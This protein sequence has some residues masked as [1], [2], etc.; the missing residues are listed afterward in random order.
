MIDMSDDG[1]VSDVVVGRGHAGSAK[2]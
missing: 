2:G 1:E